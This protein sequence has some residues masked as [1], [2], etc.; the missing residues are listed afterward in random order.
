MPVASPLDRQRPR[1]RAH[2]VRRHGK[3][4]HCTHYR[5]CT[6]DEGEQ[7]SAPLAGGHQVRR[8]RQPHD[9]NGL[10]SVSSAARA[11]AATEGV[12]DCTSELA[13]A[14]LRWYV[15]RECWRYSRG[16]LEVFTQM[17][18]ECPLYCALTYRKRLSPDRR[19]AAGKVGLSTY[20]PTCMMTAGGWTASA[21]D[22]L[23]LL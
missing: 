14:C 18:K 22:E 23:R 12:R 11:K 8:R 3:R 13:A 16:R 4:L 6:E 19:F 10:R 7:M 9:G 15:P 2:S 17:R 20:V 21:P 1:R 5:A